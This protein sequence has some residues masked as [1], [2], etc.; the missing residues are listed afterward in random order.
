[1]STK[2]CLHQPAS[3]YSSKPSPASVFLIALGKQDVLFPDGAVEAPAVPDTLGIYSLVEQVSEYMPAPQTFFLSP[4]PTMLSLPGAI[5]PLSASSSCP[6]ALPAIPNPSFRSSL[7]SS[8]DP[9]P[10]ANMSHHVT[11]F[12]CMG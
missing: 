9:P 6:Q 3:A 1:M 7:S 4:R 10:P 2:S 8:G 11:I 12:H 5:V